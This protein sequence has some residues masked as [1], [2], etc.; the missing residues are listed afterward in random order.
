M[1]LIDAEKLKNQMI[2]IAR[3]NEY[4]PQ[5]VDAL[6]ELVDAFC[7]LID[8]QPT[9]YDADKVI[10]EL[11]RDKFTGLVDKRGKRI[12][13]DD[14]LMCHGNPDELVKVVFGE[15]GVRNIE[16]GTVVDKVIGWH[17]EVIPTDAIS[18]TE[19]FCYS[20]PL[21]KDYVE[22]CEMEVMEG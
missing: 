14:I 3:M 2:A 11:K 17:Y 18:R 1:R 10:N 4:A 8:E 13:K 15:F 9:A 6:R 19:P 16:T 12:W 22:L 7:E 20:M 5:K 21:T